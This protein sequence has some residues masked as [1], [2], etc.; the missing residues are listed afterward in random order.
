VHGAKTE[1]GKGRPYGTGEPGYHK[2]RAEERIWVKNRVGPGF[3]KGKKPGLGGSTAEGEKRVFVRKSARPQWGGGESG[4]DEKKKEGSTR[5]L[6]P[7]GKERASRVS[8]KKKRQ[9]R[10]EGENAQKKGETPSEIG[11]GGMLYATKSSIRTR[12]HKKQN[13]RLIVGENL[14]LGRRL[15]LR[16]RKPTTASEKIR[17]EKMIRRKSPP[18]GIRSSHACAGEG[19]ETK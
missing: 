12:C 14:L 5:N 19:H 16:P 2:T 4:G 9:V 11:G 15:C 13:Y 7:R 8:K 3:V 10:T 18:Q 1:G 17:G 6:L